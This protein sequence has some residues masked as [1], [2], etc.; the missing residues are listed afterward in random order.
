MGGPGRGNSEKSPAE[1]PGDE[2][3][4]AEEESEEITPFAAR[5][6]LAPR[7]GRM[8]L[9]R[10]GVLRIALQEFNCSRLC[11]ELAARNGIGGL[12]ACNASC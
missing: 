7:H 5:S 9:C 10:R 11:R 8:P 12:F 3:E 6:G 2:E 4:E 1:E